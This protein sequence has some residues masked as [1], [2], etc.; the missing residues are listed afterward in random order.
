MQLL[1]TPGPAYAVQAALLSE[2]VKLGSW[3]QVAAHM[4]GVLD[5]LG[6]AWATKQ[7]SVAQE[8]LASERLQRGLILVSESLTV[9]D[10]APSCLL[11]TAEDDDHTL[12]LALI[13]VTLR[14]AG[15]QPHWLGRKMPAS[16]IADF[17]SKNSVTMVA[18]SAS[19]TSSDM[20]K[21][22]DQARIVGDACKAGQNRG[23]PWV[24]TAAGPIRR[25]PVI[26][27]APL[28]ASTAC[29]KA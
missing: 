22:E 25:R 27:Y 6:E 10:N 17:V 23:S 15:W 21:L 28:R 13:E 26:A 3:H 14:E 12:G 8:H 9:R 20:R 18:L 16:A 1:T 4:G 7:I 2:R 19:A 29:S 11:A 5:A 24:G